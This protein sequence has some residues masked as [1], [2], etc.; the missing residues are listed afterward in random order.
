MDFPYNISFFSKKGNL[1][2]KQKSQGA[3]SLK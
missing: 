3:G 2:L 1:S